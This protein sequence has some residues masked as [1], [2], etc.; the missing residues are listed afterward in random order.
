MCFCPPAI[1]ASSARLAGSV[2]STT[3]QVCK[4]E[5]VAADC[6]AAIIVASVPAGTGSG[7]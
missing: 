4:F 3:D 1:W 5:L 6:A 7:L 2:T